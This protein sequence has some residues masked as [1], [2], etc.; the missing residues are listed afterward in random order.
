MTMIHKGLV[1]IV[2]E[3]RR[4]QW[5][6]TAA[7][8][9]LAGLWPDGDERQA[10]ARHLDDGTPMVIVLEYQTSTLSALVEECRSLPEGVSVVHQAGG[11]VDLEVRELDWLPHPLRQRG[12]DFQAR[13]RAIAFSTPVHLLPP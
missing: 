7:G 1:S 3:G 13:A 2:M 9:E 4:L 5:R 11:V 8:F 10:I 6:R 12:L